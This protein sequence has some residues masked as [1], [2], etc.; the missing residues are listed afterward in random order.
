MEG[1]LYLAG[2]LGP[3]SVI[4][5]IEPLK[6]D[7][8][9][10]YRTDRLI[11]VQSERDPAILLLA[12][13][14]K[15]LKWTHIMLRQFVLFSVPES[16]AWH[17]TGRLSL[18]HGRESSPATVPLLPAHCQ[19]NNDRFVHFKQS[20]EA[21]WRCHIP[22]LNSIKGAIVVRTT[23]LPHEALRTLVGHQFFE[24]LCWLTV[25]CS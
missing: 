19:N 9:Q 10:T 11:M 2:L 14:H 15:L 23:A 12:D 4:W 13:L 3:G 5:P 18:L 6:L 21:E 20:P 17:N 22:T 25:A 8:S 16:K 1:L 24:I 7:Y